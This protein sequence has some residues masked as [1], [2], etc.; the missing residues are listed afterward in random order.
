VNPISVKIA[1]E[2]LLDLAV[3][4]RLALDAGLSVGTQYDQRGKTNLDARLRAF[5]CAARFE[6]W[7]IARDLDQDCDCP[8]ELVGKLIPQLAPWLCLR[9]PVTSIE[10]WLLADDRGFASNHKVSPAQVSPCPDALP[11]AKQAMLGLL[12][13]SKSKVIRESMCIQ[14]ENG[15]LRIGPEYNQRLIEFVQSDWNVLRACKNSASLERP[16]HRIKEFTGRCE[17]EWGSS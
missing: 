7:L 17:Q 16:V 9:I 1:G 14:K 4:R 11:N 10:S 8:G 12:F 3:L 2:G 5:N 6:P 13:V 15:L